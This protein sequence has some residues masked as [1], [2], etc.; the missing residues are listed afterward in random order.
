M[1]APETTSTPSKVGDL[2]RLILESEESI[3]RL[4]ELQK[5]PSV[6]LGQRATRHFRKHGGNIVNAALAGCVFVVALGRLSQKYQYQVGRRGR[7]P[8]ADIVDCEGHA[9]C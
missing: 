6:S 3:K 5:R 1:A 8:C 2:D 7:G 4:E 9:R